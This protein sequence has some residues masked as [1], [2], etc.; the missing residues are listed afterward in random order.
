[1]RV[2]GGLIHCITEFFPCDFQ[3]LITIKVRDRV[4]VR[5]SGI[6]MSNP[7]CTALTLPAIVKLV[8][9]SIVTVIVAVDVNSRCTSNCDGKL[10]RSL[11]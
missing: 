8:F 11:L 4:K 3:H 2:I 10:A 7:S 5:V 6:S 1:M 9:T